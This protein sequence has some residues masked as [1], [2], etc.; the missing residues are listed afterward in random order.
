MIKP[1][2]DRILIKQ[3]EIDNVT[4]SGIILPDS[5]LND[6]PLAGTVI[7]VGISD[8]IKVGERILFNRFSALNNVNDGGIEYL[9]IRL[10]DVIAVL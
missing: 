7:A 3:D 5:S 10:E 4:K 2:R 1:F 6:K 8:E 9:I